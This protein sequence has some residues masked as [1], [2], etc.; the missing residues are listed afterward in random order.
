MSSRS[1][2]PP[3]EPGLSCTYDDGNRS[4]EMH[5]IA[6]SFEDCI[7]TYTYKIK[8]LKRSSRFVQDRQKRLLTLTHSDGTV[9]HVRDY[10]AGLI[11]VEPDPETGEM[12]P[13]TKHGEPVYVYFCREEREGG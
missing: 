4:D 11:A 1:A 8:P 6:N 9:E 5:E 7:T 3:R 2:S 12:H 10:P 13:V